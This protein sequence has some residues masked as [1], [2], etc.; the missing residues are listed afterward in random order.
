MNLVS[1][2]DMLIAEQLVIMQFIESTRVKQILRTISDCIDL[3]RWQS[4]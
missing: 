2:D 3:P 1:F 4:D